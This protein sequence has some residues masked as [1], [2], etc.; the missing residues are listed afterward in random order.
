VSIRRRQ[1]KLASCTKGGDKEDVEENEDSDEKEEPVEKT[2]EEVSSKSKKK[3]LESNKTTVIEDK[4]TKT[5]EPVEAIM[6]S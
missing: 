4:S 5:S 2:T 6:L 3:N 1:S